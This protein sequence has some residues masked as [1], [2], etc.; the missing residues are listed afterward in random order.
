MRWKS[1]FLWVLHLMVFSAIFPPG[2]SA[3]GVTPAEAK[4][5]RDEVRIVRDMF[6]HAFDGYIKHAF[7]LDELRPLTCKGEDSLGGYALTLVRAIGLH[8]LQIDSLDTLALLGDRERFNAAVDWV[9]ENVRFDI[10]KTVSVFETTIRI[11]GGLLSAHLIAS[12]YATNGSPGL[13]RALARSAQRLGSGDR[14][15]GAS[16]KRAAWRSGEVLGPRLSA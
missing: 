4:E 11:L 3:D 13:T 1:L 8:N 15:G 12:D 9:S 5:L 2:V 6:Y 16:L 14:P 7:P 10:D